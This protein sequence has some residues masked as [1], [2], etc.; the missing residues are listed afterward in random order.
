MTCVC[1][2]VQVCI[3]MW[4]PCWTTAMALQ[5]GQW[6]RLL[7]APRHTRRSPTMAPQAGVAM[8]RTTQRGIDASSSCWRLRQPC[9]YDAPLE[10]M[11]LVARHLDDWVGQCE[12]GHREQAL[13]QVHIEEYPRAAQ[14]WRPAPMLGRQTARQL[15]QEWVPHFVTLCLG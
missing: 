3:G 11:V 12:G 5:H 10:G 2:G 9:E 13:Q 14:A 6:H 8:S 15:L 1:Q 7:P 4:L